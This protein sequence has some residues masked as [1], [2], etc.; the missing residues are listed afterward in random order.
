MGKTDDLMGLTIA[1]CYLVPAAGLLVQNWEGFSPRH[2]A[3]PIPTSQLED[4]VQNFDGIEGDETILRI[5]GKP[6]GLV[7][8]AHGEPD[9]VPYRTG[10][11]E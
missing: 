1:V 3:N 10:T 2:E 11:E 7:Y 6:Y 4:E 9:L 5:G 8:D